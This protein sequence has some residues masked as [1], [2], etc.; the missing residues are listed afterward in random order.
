MVRISSV[1]SLFERS[2]KRKPWTSHPK[3]TSQLHCDK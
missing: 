2:S 1:P 3:S